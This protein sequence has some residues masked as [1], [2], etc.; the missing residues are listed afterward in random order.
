[1]VPLLGMLC[2]ILLEVGEELHD[3]CGIHHF[4]QLGYLLSSLVELYEDSIL[5]GEVSK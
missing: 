5:V 4:V 1:M 3:E 2:E